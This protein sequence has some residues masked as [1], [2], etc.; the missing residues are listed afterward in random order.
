MFLTHEDLVELTGYKKPALQKRWM[1][2]H[3]WPFV[4]NAAGHPK[5]LRSVVEKQMGGAPAAKETKRQK[6]NLGAIL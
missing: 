2:D 1:L 3:G 5:I 6:P 4:E